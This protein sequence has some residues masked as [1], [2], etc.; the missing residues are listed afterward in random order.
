MKQSKANKTR[1]DIE[2][3]VNKKWN[4]SYKTQSQEREK[5]LIQ[6]R[7]SE[8]PRQIFDMMIDDLV[9]DIEHK[10]KKNLIANKTNQNN[11][12][13]KSWKE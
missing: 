8:G 12:L 9:R 1:K 3:F 2:M 11:K 4:E 5:N 7:I 10:D 13:Y 6:R